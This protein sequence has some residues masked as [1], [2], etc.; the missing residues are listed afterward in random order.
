MGSVISVGV[1]DPRVAEVVTVSIIGS[2]MR[3]V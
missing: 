1:M 2:I 3:I